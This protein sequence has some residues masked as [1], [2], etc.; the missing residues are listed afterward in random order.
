[1][2]HPHMT[3]AIAGLLVFTVM[4]ALPARA[5]EPRQPSAEKGQVLAQTLCNTCHLV[6]GSVAGQVT[7]GI[8]SFRGIANRLGQTSERIRNV[9]ID[10]HPP[11]PNVR[12]SN[13]E[14]SDLIAFLETLRTNDKVQPLSPRAPGSP[15]AIPK[16]S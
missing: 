15:P 10:P 6:D 11:M 16:P 13:D 3:H 14:I 8:P 12:L 4:S 9:L 5:E 7:V 1:M 2:L